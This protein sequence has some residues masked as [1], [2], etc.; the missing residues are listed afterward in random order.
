MV[1][2]TFTDSGNRECG[3]MKHLMKIIAVLLFAAATL[4]VSADNL[5]KNTTFS[6]ADGW[7]FWVNK[8]VADAGGAGTLQDG[9]AVAKSPAIEKQKP[10][11]IQLIKPINVEADKSYKFTFKANVEK[12]GHL[13][14]TY[15]MSNSP[16]TGYASS[17]INLEPGKTNYECILVI[18]RDTAGNYDAPRSLRLYFGAF[19]DATVTVSDVS[20]EE[21]K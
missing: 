13:I 1:K 4:T 5:L 11:D 16:Y 6:K 7:F 15:G 19:K 2:K 21:V 12:A 8:S 20:F 3:I 17:G 14:I 10:T 18:K 9:K